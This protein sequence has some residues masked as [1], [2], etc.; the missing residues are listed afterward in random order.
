MNNKIFINPLQNS[1]LLNNSRTMI[2]IMQI[3]SSLPV[4]FLLQILQ[5][6]LVFPALL[7]KK[8]SGIALID[9]WEKFLENKSRFPGIPFTTLLFLFFF[10]FLFYFDQ[11]R[12][13]QLL[14]FTQMVFTLIYSC[15]SSPL[16]QKISFFGTN[17]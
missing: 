15:F 5:A 10:S 7:T 4:T 16:L 11:I 8:F 12:T 9:F 2:L 14:R 3:E 1:M 13:T 6:V 17:L